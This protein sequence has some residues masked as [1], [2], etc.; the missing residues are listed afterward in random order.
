MITPALDIPGLARSYSGG[1]KH[2]DL[3]VTEAADGQWVVRLEVYGALSNKDDLAG[4][5]PNEDGALEVVREIFD[6]GHIPDS[7]KQPVDDWGPDGCSP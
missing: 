4:R 6:T 3:E 7:L 1:W 2:Y 5:F